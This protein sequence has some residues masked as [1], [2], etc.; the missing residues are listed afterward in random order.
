MANKASTP[1]IYALL[2][3]VNDYTPNV[4]K[5][6]GCLNDVDH[7]HDFLKSKF[8]PSKLAIEIRKDSEATRQ[9]IIDGFRN[10]LC[11]AGPDDVVLFQFSGHGARWKSSKQFNE[12]YPDGF[13]E[14]LICWDS[15]R[16][17]DKPGSFDLADKELAVLVAEVAQKNPHVVVIL[18]C[19]H[20]GSGTRSADDFA[21]MAVRKSHQIEKERP[22]ESYL[23]GYYQKRL[24]QSQPLDTPTSRHILLAACERKKQAFEGHDRRGIF[25]STLLNLLDERGVNSTYSDLFIR[26]RATVRRKAY[27]Q[28]PQFEVFRGFNGHAGFLGSKVSSSSTKRFLVNF[29]NQRKSWT[30]DCGAIQGIVSESDKPIEFSVFKE[31]GDS[32]S[33]G[34]ARSTEVGLS[35]TSI[36]LGFESAKTENYFG[37]VTSLPAPPLPVGWQGDSEIKAKIDA[38][39]NSEEGFPEIQIVEDE[40]ASFDYTISAEEVPN[41][42]LCLLLKQTATNQ[43]V[44]GVRGK[45]EL[46]IKKI[47]ATTDQVAI[48]ERTL[49]LQN[50]SNQADTNR[51]PFKFVELDENGEHLDHPGTKIRFDLAGGDEEIISGKFQVRND[52]AQQ[53]YTMLVYF[54]DGYG[55][56]V[57]DNDELP[58]SDSWKTILLDGDPVFELMLEQDGPSQANERFMLI[59]SD[60]RVDEFLLGSD[61]DH[62]LAD[63]DAE[64]RAVLSPM[65]L[66]KII[67]AG[68]GRKIRTGKRKIKDIKWFTKTIEIQIAKTNA[69][70]A[71]SNVDIAGGAIQ[72][73]GHPSM[74]ANV[75]MTALPMGGRG[76]GNDSGFIESLETGGMSLVNFSNAR[77]EAMSVLELSEI[78]NSE[79]LAAQPLEIEINTPL[80]ANESI[81]PL[82]FDG[83]HIL[84]AGDSWKD[85]NGKVHIRIDEIPEVDDGRRS[86][87]SSLKM[88]FFKTYLNQKNINQI[89][90]VKFREKGPLGLESRSLADKVADAKNIVVLVHG[91]LSDGHA[92]ASRSRTSQAS[93]LWS[94]LG[95]PND[96]TLLLTYDYENLHTPLDQ[97]AV[98]LKN[99]LQQI[100]IDEKSDKYVTVIGHSIGGLVAR[101][102]IEQEGGNQ[103]VDHLVMLGTP[104]GGCPF[105]K[106]GPACKIIKALATIGIN[107]FPPFAAAGGFILSVL[108][109]V[110]KFTATLEQ[111]HPRGDFLTRLNSSSDPG[112]QYTIYSGDVAAATSSDAWLDQ[113]LVKMGTSK[114]FDKIFNHETHDLFV[115]AASCEQINRS[116]DP[117][118]VTGEISCHHLA[119]LKGELDINLA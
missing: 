38:L 107:T 78:Q 45:D 71:E 92:M 97:T 62:A 26:I 54:C 15:R 69:T 51:V 56:Y 105:G 88:Y 118:P 34:T 16:E 9:G 83:E 43:L 87:F 77:D 8:D 103:F 119:Y 58:P 3:G 57:L 65:E 89:R 31:D 37:E 28:T 85:D 30:V 73:A 112:I 109:N 52:T 63:N 104:N 117:K 81:T 96:D 4:G 39:Q 99:Q 2:A 68:Q 36:E 75:S 86:V 7:Y 41:E 55:M 18:D 22:I 67:D 66:G 14:G 11:Q 46:S 108:L 98:D 27:N 90:W 50:R 64:S 116:R 93:D 82:V 47:L 113:L 101:W 6:K 110:N 40:N 32:T 100:G 94:D 33:I 25:S 84:L 79:S 53:L 106:V 72:I 70:I 17:P 13:D 35:R 19:C 23:D 29:D 12:Y 10:H 61:S 20:S 1:R 76:V 91:L 21:Q 5:L 74:K 111:L 42:G 49:A 102:M 80:E 48:W 60:E 44:Q 95:I 114:L 24:D 59:V 115:T